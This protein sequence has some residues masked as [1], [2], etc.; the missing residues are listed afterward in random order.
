MEPRLFFLL[1]HGRAGTTLVAD[2]LAAHPEVA[3][4]DEAKVFDF[5]FFAG[6]WAALPD[7]ARLRFEL[8]EPVELRGLVRRDQAAAFGA[9]FAEHARALALEYY[10]RAF[11]GKRFRV[12]GDKMPH[13]L[14][15][16]A[17]RGPFPDALVFAF[18]RDPRDYLCS[19]RAY[20]RK[21]ALRERFPHLDVGAREHLVHWR[22]VVLGILERSQ[23][24]ARIV[25][26]EDLLRDPRVVVDALLAD[27]GLAPD[28]ACHAALAARASFARHGTSQTPE[29]SLGRWRLE[30]APAERALARE[31]CGEAAARLGYPE[32]D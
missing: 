19:A 12:F 28:P 9:L 27:L 4:T 22:N 17:A 21:P 30:L 10:R 32:V 2:A 20:A 16:L 3:L 29:A 15:A 5:L 1:S 23:D 24:V 11:P 14:A 26:Y 6:Q 25:R 18:V 13:P 31:V 8:E 7:D